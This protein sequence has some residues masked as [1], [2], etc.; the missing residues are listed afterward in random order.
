MKS[1][2]A[3]ERVPLV[4]SLAECTW[5]V[6]AAPIEEGVIGSPPLAECDDAWVATFVANSHAYPLHV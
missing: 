2:R 6:A 5:L 4:M 1:K 3:C